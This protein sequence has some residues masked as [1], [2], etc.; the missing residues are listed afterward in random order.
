MISCLFLLSFLRSVCVVTG[1]DK[2]N[3]AEEREEKERKEIS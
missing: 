3:D 1:G 2:M